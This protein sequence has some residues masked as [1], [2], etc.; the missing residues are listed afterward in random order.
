VKRRKIVS[1][2][3]KRGLFNPE[4]NMN[5]ETPPKIPG[6]TWGNDP[7]VEATVEAE[8]QAL[9]EACD[10]GR[11]CWGRW[12]YNPSEPPS[13]DILPDDSGE[14]YWFTMD[15]LGTTTEIGE[16]L[17]HIGRKT[18][19]TA[20]DLGQFARAI[21]DLQRIGYVSVRHVE[22]GRK[23]PKSSAN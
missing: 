16:W 8:E 21:L 20:D 2:C 22:K 3:S 7:E 12:K 15:E 17:L 6:I 14:P 19:T 1:S 13:L 9:R 23:L 10:D 5:D 4:D 18:W 11:Q